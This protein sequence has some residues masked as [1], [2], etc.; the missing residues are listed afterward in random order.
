M[1]NYDNPRHDPT[2]NGTFIGTNYSIFL[3]HNAVE[4]NT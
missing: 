4:C 2:D 3:Y 1:L